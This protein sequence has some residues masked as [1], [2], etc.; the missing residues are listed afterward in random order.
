MSTGGLNGGGPP[1][2]RGREAARTTGSGPERISA[3][4][5]EVAR[6]FGFNGALELAAVERAWLKVVGP[7]VAAHCRPLSVRD[8][9]L[10]IGVDHSAWASELRLLQAELLARVR[11]EAPGI[12]RLRVQVSPPEGEGW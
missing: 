6:R 8:G 3:S 1:R 5:G 10:T 11:A 7:Q 9:C 12:E 4:L 2:R